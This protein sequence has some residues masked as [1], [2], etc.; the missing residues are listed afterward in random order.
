M[1]IKTNNYLYQISAD[2]VEVVS[3]PFL[4]ASAI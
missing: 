2:D 1:E 3:V 4:N